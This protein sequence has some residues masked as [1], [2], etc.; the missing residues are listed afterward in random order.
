LIETPHHVQ[1]TA[2]AG[3]DMLVAQG[4]DADSHTGPS[5]LISLARQIVDAAGDIPVLVAGGEATGRHVAAALAASAAG[6]WI[7]TA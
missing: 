1:R 2:A 6:V 4:Y 7:G 3:V 5:V